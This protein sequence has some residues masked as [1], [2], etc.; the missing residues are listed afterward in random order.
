MSH[1]ITLRELRDITGEPAHVINHALDRHGPKPAGRIGLIRYWRKSD[2]AG[3]LEAL[4]KT[5]AH[6][7]S[8]T[9]KREAVGT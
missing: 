7:N 9:P 4:A 2:L 1:T 6:H 8:R 3:I 5:A